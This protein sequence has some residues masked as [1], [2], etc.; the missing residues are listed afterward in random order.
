MHVSQTG[1]SINPGTMP[2]THGPGIVPVILQTL[3]FHDVTCQITLQRCIAPLRAIHLT[4]AG[5]GSLFQ[6]FGSDD[7]SNVVLIPIPVQAIP[8]AFE[9]IRSAIDAFPVAVAVLPGYP[10]H[11][12][13]EAGSRDNV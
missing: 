4:T 1:R 3:S 6:V 13:R 5:S 12:F 2:N 11:E 7:F 10:R 9:G 8:A